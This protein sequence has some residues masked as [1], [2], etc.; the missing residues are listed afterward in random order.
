MPPQGLNKCV[1]SIFELQN[2]NIRIFFQFFPKQNGPANFTSLS[3]QI[4]PKCPI[5]FC[6]PRS[7]NRAKVLYI[8]KKTASNDFPPFNENV[9]INV[10][11]HGIIISRPSKP[12]RFSETHF[13]AK[14]S[15]NFVDLKKSVILLFKYVLHQT[16][17]PNFFQKINF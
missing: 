6:N 15:S 10:F 12:N 3:F 1:F 9:S 4:S 17:A 16:F 8:L 14:N 5:N 2:S 7:E 13:F 11:I